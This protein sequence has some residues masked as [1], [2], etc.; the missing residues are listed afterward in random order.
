MLSI[1]EMELSDKKEVM[2]MVDE[3]YNSDAVLHKVDMSILERSFMDAAGDE[4]S[5]CGAVLSEGDDVVGFAYMAMTYSC[6]A[7][8]KTI[9]L[10]ELYLKDQ[11]R[12]KG[13]G[14]KFFNWMFDSFPEVIRF[15]LEV[16]GKNEGAS[17]LY[18]RLGFEDLDYNQMI[19]DRNM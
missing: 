10:E 15:R 5:V 9:M 11:C 2:D 14:K 18:R 13:Y 3:F 19:F 12:G 1:R 16:T 8:G 6:E 7:G 17:A 4:P